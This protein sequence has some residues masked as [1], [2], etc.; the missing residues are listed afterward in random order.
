MG[1]KGI[2]LSSVKC[3]CAPSFGAD[4]MTRRGGF[5]LYAFGADIL[6]A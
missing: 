6:W 1:L 3:S 4:S 2:T 5:V